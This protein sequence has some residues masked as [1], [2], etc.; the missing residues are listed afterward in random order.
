M[1]KSSIFFRHE[2]LITLFSKQVCYKLVLTQHKCSV[3]GIFLK[4][5]SVH[6]PLDLRHNKVLATVGST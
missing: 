6:K 3:T 2:S 5:F 4:T 1:S